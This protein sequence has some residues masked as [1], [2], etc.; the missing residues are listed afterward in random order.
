MF[1]DVF[2][3]QAEANLEQAHANMKQAGADQACHET[4]HQAHDAEERCHRDGA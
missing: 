4:L 1:W 3:E 2:L